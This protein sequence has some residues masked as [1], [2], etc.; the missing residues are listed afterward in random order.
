MTQSRDHS[1]LGCCQAEL[2]L[3]SDLLAKG[4]TGGRCSSR[5]TFP[6]LLSF[7]AAL[8]SERFPMTR[9]IIVER[10]YPHALLLSFCSNREEHIP[11]SMQL[12]LTTVPAKVKR[13][14][15]TECTQ[16]LAWCSSDDMSLGRCIDR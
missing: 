8:A 6:Q 11:R 15:G 3:G 7:K 4:Q 10:R 2:T 14:S 1:L 5:S 13:L 12:F 9:L 16:S